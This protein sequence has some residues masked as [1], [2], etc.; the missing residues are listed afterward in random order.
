MSGR[1]T[2]DPSVCHGKPCIAGT[3]IPVD[4]ILELIGAGQTPEQIIDAYPQLVEED[5]RAAVQYA[6]AVLEGEAV[7]PLVRG[8]KITTDKVSL[9]DEM[10]D[11]IIADLR[12]VGYKGK[13]LEGKLFQRKEELGWAFERMLEEARRD[14]VVP[15]KSRIWGK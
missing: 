13:E 15:E 9:L 4:Q 12:E 14:E 6:A 2:V 3:R 7:L 11:L 8:D 5:I 10:E 1:I